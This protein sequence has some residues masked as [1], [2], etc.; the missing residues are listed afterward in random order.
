MNHISRKLLV[1]LVGATLI[2][3]GCTKKPRPAPVDTTVTGGPAAAGAISPENLNLTTPSAGG[4]QPRPEG[5]IEDENTIRGLL[6]AV[7]F[8]FDS[9]AIKRDERAKITDAADYLKKNMQYRMLLEGHCDWRG[10][11]EYN[12]GLG[13]R[14][15]QSVRQFLQDLGI[16]KDRLETLSKGSLGATEHGAEDVMAKERRVEFVILKK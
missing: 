1:A 7:Y 13:D 5:V 2:F 3:A 9:P 14:R 16:P 6:K 4:L 12:L 15:A 11:A 8:D 10:T